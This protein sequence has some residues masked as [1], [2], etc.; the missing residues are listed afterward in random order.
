MQATQVNL[1]KTDMS[2]SAEDKTFTLKDPVLSSKS[3]GGVSF[4]SKNAAYK[5]NSRRR[6]SV[7][8][9]FAKLNASGIAD[10]E[11]MSNVVKGITQQIGELEAKN[12]EITQTQHELEQRI[13]N[14]KE[15][16]LKVV[17]SRSTK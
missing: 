14:I 8:A 3:I 1:G 15:R 17:K 12:K 4:A 13:D 16:L 2:A 9:T 11:E 10:E 5:E 7:L 6:N